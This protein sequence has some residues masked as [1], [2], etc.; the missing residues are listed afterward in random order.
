MHR[1]VFLIPFFIIILNACTDSNEIHVKPMARAIGPDELID[2][3]T[4]I[5]TSEDGV[6]WIMTAQHVK[7]FNQQKKWT[8]YQV[9][10]ESTEEDNKNF[11]E[12]DSAYISEVD[13]IFTGMGNVVIIS[14]KGILKTQKIEWN[15]KTNK[16][17]APGFVYLKKDENEF[18]GTN[19][20]TNINF[21]Y[22]DLKEVSGQG[23]IEEDMFE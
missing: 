8:A 14:P 17:R 11:Y 10:I 9:F 6:D 21:D 4:I 1:L 3:L 2:S 7:K 19:L 16:I 20:F 5:S 13:D 23:I 22:I 12:S 18:T 15:R